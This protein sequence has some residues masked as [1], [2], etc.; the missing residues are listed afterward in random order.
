MARFSHRKAAAA[1]LLAGALLAK[2]LPTLASPPGDPSWPS[3]GFTDVSANPLAVYLD[4]RDKAGNQQHVSAASIPPAAA[5]PQLQQVLGNPVLSTPLGTYFDQQWTTATVP[6]TGEVLRDAACDMIKNKIQSEVQDNLHTN[7]KDISCNL[8]RS[9]A[10][11]VQVADGT[12]SPNEPPGWHEPAPFYLWSGGQHARIT[13]W[14]PGNSAMFSVDEDYGLGNPRY[15]L[16]FDGEMRI[17]ANISDGNGVDMCTDSV[18]DWAQADDATI[19]P[20]NVAGQVY[21]DVGALVA[22]LNGQPTNLFQTAEGQIDSGTFSVPALGSVTSAFDQLAAA[23]NSGRS[24]GFSQMQASVSNGAL[25]FRFTHADLAQPTLTDLAAQHNSSSFLTDSLGVQNVQV[26]AGDTDAVTGYFDMPRSSIEIGWDPKGV[27]ATVKWSIKGQN[28]PPTTANVSGSEFDITSPQSNTQYDFEVQECDQVSCSAWSPPLDIQTEN[29]DIASVLLQL[30]NGPVV[31]HGTVKPDGTLAT[32]ITVPAST[33]PGSYTL[34]ALVGNNQ[35]AST[36]LTVLGT[37]ARAQPVLA[38]WDTA[39]NR[40]TAGPAVTTQ[41]GEFTLHGEAFAPGQVTVRLDNASGP[42]IG[43]ATAGADGSFKG[44]FSMPY[45]SIGNH[46]LVT[47][48]TPQAS[49]AV[50]VEGGVQ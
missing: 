48:S 32:T 14:L 26:H 20:T 33:K 9:G 7:A 13:Y 24:F 45:T 38:A 28:Q 35:T 21:D 29:Q 44:T 15:N 46:T 50:T 10:V 22:D 49:L 5:P 6:Q 39:A 25:T 17:L 11:G 34:Q 47:D 18:Y 16:T 31:G 2:P 43:S 12:L 8:P 1:L 4:F 42:V 27:P 30:E 37:S 40:A 3:E 41:G 36:S 19:D 23:C